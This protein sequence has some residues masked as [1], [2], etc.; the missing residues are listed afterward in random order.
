[1][2]A[3]KFEKR[4]DH[5]KGVSLLIREIKVLTE[6]SGFKG[7]Y[8]LVNRGFPQ[9]KFYGRDD[10]YNFFMESYLGMNLE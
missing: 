5:E 8:D 9:L 6:V 3:A 1:M 10:H 2:V 4:N 7:I